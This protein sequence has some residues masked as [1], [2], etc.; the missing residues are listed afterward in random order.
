M[1]GM[2]M[3]GGWTMSMTWMRMPGQTWPGAA[4]SFLGMWV[5]MM[6]AM[7]L[8]SLVPTLWRYRQAVQRAGVA[9]ID[10]LTGLAG[11]GYFCVWTAIGMAVF[12]LGVALAA[13]EMHLP[14]LSRGVPIATGVIVVLAGAL[15]FSTW[16]AQRLACCRRS[17]GCDGRWA[18]AGA[19]AWRHGLRLGLECTLCCGG[20]T[21]ILLVAGVMD[22]RVMAAVT[23]AITAERLA[24][25][26]RRVARGIGA[27]AV[28]AGLFLILQAM[29]AGR[30]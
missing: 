25:D 1:G 8:P 4:A 3:P 2:P 11:A 21:G 20:L 15:Q 9:R 16:K 26:A 5:V 18:G 10:W 13:S 14:A 27:G 19:T 28:S 24:R 29:A 6:V 7:M 22:L 23:A 12:P 30:P 17:P